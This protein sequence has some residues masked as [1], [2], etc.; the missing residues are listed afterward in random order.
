LLRIRLSR[1]GKKK[2]PAYRIVVADSRS[3]RDGAFLKII[4]HYNPLTDPA[5]L[6]VKEEEAIH[7][8]TKGAQPSDT[9]AKLLTRLGVM[10]RAGKAPVR[11]QGKDVPPGARPKKGVEPSSAPTP[12]TA[13]API[14]APAAVAEA[15]E[16]EAASVPIG[17]EAETM[18]VEASA[19]VEVDQPITEPEAEPVP[20][21]EA[22]VEPEPHTDEESPEQAE[23]TE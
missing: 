23:S 11:Y 20:D 2:Q 4:G 12:V 22:A 21:E 15:P 3:P 5:T 9:A 1:V 6:V 18:E 8:L 10:E 17:V 7:W 19:E 14:P 13:A 16:A